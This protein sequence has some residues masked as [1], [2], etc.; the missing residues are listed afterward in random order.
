MG[1]YQA[2][3]VYIEEV[4]SGV[5]PLAGVGTSTAGFIGLAQWGEA[6][7]AVLITSWAEFVRKFGGLVPAYQLGYAVYGFFAEGGK[8]CY[9]VRVAREV[10]AGLETADPDTTAKEASE[11][12]TI[13]TVSYFTVQ[14]RSVGEWGNGI[15]V[16]IDVGQKPKFRV[17]VYFNGAREVYEANDFKRLQEMVNDKS[18]LITMIHDEKTDQDPDTIP[19]SDNPF[20]IILKNGG[21]KLPVEGGGA[22]EIYCGSALKI[23]NQNQDTSP[24]TDVLTIASRFNGEWSNRITIQISDTPGQ[25]ST[26]K[27]FDLTVRYENYEHHYIGLTLT[28]IATVATNPITSDPVILAAV[29]SSPENSRPQNGFYTLTGG[30]FDLE[31]KAADLRL[32]ATWFINP[33]Q[34]KS[35]LYALDLVE[36]V[37]ILAVPDMA[38]KGEVL[39][40]VLGY[41]GGRR[42]CIL[43]GDPPDGEESEDVKKF[44]VTYLQNPNGYGALYYPWILIYDPV[45]KKARLTPPSGMIAGAYAYTDASRGV[46]KA[47]A[48]IA[49]GYLD[50]ALGVE[51][52]V[53]RKEQELL[54]PAGINVI[55]SLPAGICIWGAR[56][57]A[58]DGEWQYINIRRLF[59]YLE[60][61]IEQGSRWVVFEPN[62]PILWGKVKRNLT[63]FLL[64]LWRDGALSGS[65][66]EEAFFVKVDA[67]NNPPEVRDS[68]QLIIEVG[69][70]PVKPAEF[71]V[72]RVS[73]MTL[74]K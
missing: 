52:T 60:K 4:S 14:A 8:K 54:N 24:P 11:R 41:C 9:I 73:Q 20:F 62:D 28:T 64:R 27:Q 3:G 1:N 65:S 22:K 63:A 67:D 42:D 34:P 58:T 43:I 37:S 29:G 21:N 18:V 2:P 70:A 10:K 40:A 30:G 6:D 17:A 72:I 47:P 48:G 38:G 13:G 57:V 35:G 12:V 33:S 26:S 39:K 74:A 68:G 53:T 25:A 19:V 23:L 31:L 50:L 32:P 7:K 36:D 56:T 66:P 44:K 59:I 71:V 61:S 15:Q 49:E 51:R 16:T 69:V 5:K 55:R 45:T 46:H